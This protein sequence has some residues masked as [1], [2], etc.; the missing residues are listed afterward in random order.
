MTTTANPKPTPSTGNSARVLRYRARHRRI[1]YV[2]SPE[3]LAII[4][5]WLNAKLN[6]CRAGVIDDLVR[7]GHKAISGNGQVIPLSKT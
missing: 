6:N 4:E 1:D 2:P 5:G 3:V 7:A